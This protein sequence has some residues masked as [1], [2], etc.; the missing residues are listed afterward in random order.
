MQPAKRQLPSSQPASGSKFTAKESLHPGKTQVTP[1][2]NGLG[3]VVAGRRI[4]TGRIAARAAAIVTSRIGV[5]IA[6]AGVRAPGVGATA[7]VVCCGLAEVAGA[8]VR[9]AQHFEGVAHAVRHR[10]RPSTRHRNPVLVP[11]KRSCHS[12]WSPR[13]CSCRP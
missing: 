10:H 12:G 13:H 8:L 6:E 1:P 7:V 4:Q 3:V 2:A 5:V 11:G 9:A